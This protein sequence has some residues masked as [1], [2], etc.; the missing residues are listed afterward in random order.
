[1]DLAPI[2]SAGAQGKT[3]VHHVELCNV[4]AT[5]QCLGKTMKR[6]LRDLAKPRTIN[7]LIDRS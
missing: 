1:M 2:L 3:I 4:L 5:H 6:T 7:V